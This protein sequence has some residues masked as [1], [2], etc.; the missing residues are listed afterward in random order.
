MFPT[1][2]ISCSTP[3]PKKGLC[4]PTTLSLQAFDD[5]GNPLPAPDTRGRQP[6]LAFAATKLV[7]Q[8]DNQAC[9]GC[10]QRMAERDRAAIH[11]Y[12]IAIKPKFLLHSEI[13]RRESLVH[14][15]QVDVI[16]RQSRFLQRDPA[17]RNR[18][19]A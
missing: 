17:S 16:Q 9:T 3:S 2:L 7:H 12:F 11:V 5:D 19:R 4:H 14:L 13:L 15:H 18:P 10:A 8:R 6:V 1:L